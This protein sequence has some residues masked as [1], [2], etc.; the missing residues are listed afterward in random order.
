MPATS[1]TICIASAYWRRNACQRDS[2]SCCRELVGPDLG[3][4]ALDLGAREALGGIDLLARRACPRSRGRARPSGCR[5]RCAGPV[6]DSPRRETGPSLLQPSGARGSRSGE[7]L[8]L[9][10]A[11]RTA[12]A[13]GPAGPASR[14]FSDRH[15]VSTGSAISVAPPLD[16]ASGGRGG[17]RDLEGDPDVAGDAPP[18]LDLVDPLGVGRVGELEGRAP[19]VEDRDPPVAGRGTRPARAARA[20]RGRRRGPPRSPAP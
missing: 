3:P 18:D 17:V 4:A 15:G 14:E 6:M 16:E 13:G 1:S 9:G 12:S 20:R 10:R 5:W 2:V 8:G 19:G 11:A 7:R